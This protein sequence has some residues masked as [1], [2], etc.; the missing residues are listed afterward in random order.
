[1]APFSSPPSTSTAEKKP[2]PFEKKRVRTPAAKEKDKLQHRASRQNETPEQR[3]ARLDRLSFRRR[4]KTATRNLERHFTQ[5]MSTND[6]THEQTMA[7]LAAEQRIQDSKTW[8]AMANARA[9]GHKADA[10]TFGQIIAKQRDDARVPAVVSSSSSSSVS[11]YSSGQTG[12]SGGQGV[13]TGNGLSSGSGNAWVIEDSML[14]KGY[15]IQW[16]GALYNKVFAGVKASV[17]SIVQTMP[18]KAIHLL[19]A[20]FVWGVE[21]DAKKTNLEVLCRDEKDILAMLDW[22]LGHAKDYQQGL[23]VKGKVDWLAGTFKPKYYAYLAQP[24]K[25]LAVHQG[26]LVE[27]TVK[28][29]DSNGSLAMEE[30]GSLPFHQVLVHP[31]KASFVFQ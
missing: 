14:P 12:S 20:S 1:M 16:D 21:T 7:R 31:S 13:A 9:E 30:G 8:E 26:S 18:I 23:D 5:T 6:P 17:E 22:F 28:T 3:R 10:V 2:P 4:K 24:G 15:P 11:S 29:V 19:A 27:A 25:V